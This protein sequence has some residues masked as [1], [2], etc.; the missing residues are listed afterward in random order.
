MED[1]L[2]ACANGNENE[3]KNWISQGVKTSVCDANGNNG[4]HLAVLNGHWGLAWKLTRLYQVSPYK[5]N[6][7]GDS[8]YHSIIR[9]S[10]YHPPTHQSYS[11]FYQLQQEHWNNIL[12]KRAQKIQEIA[13]ATNV[14]PSQNM[15]TSSY[16]S[17][18]DEMFGNPYFT[19]PLYI[20]NKFNVSIRNKNSAGLTPEALAR[21]LNIPELAEFFRV[22][23]GEAK[24]FLRLMASL[25]NNLLIEVAIYL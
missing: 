16:A 18:K 12:Q 6:N 8:I 1:F 23:D 19:L 25:N 13:C 4:V 10:I 20:L 11:D 14:N 2:A 5:I 21:E 15:L 24:R 7:Q 22:H 3:V 9:A 17:L